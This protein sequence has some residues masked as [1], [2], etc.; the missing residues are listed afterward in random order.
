LQRWEYFFWIAI[1]SAAVVFHPSHLAIV[2]VLLVAAIIGWVLSTSISPSGVM[3]LAVAATIG[4]AS[5][6][7]FAFAVEKVLHVWVSRPPDLMARI[8]ADGPGAMYL[9][10]RCPQAGFLAC[11]FVDRLSQNSDQILWGDDDVYAPAP[12]SA[13]ALLG[14][15]QYQFEAAVLAYDP[16]AVITAALRDTF[17]QLKMAG[18]ASFDGVEKEAFPKLP[19]VYAEQLMTTR[20]WNKDFPIAIFSTLTVLVALLSSIFVG[21]TLIRNWRDISTAQKVFCFVVLFAQVANAAICG[22]FS[23]P[24][25]RYQARLTWLIPITALL[26]YYAM[27]ERRCSTEEYSAGQALSLPIASLTGRKRIWSR[28]ITGLSCRPV[29]GLLGVLGW[30]TKS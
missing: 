27:R 15:E 18:L 20:L 5:E 7:G 12:I 2:L 13:R 29:L 4:F 28:P 10:H 26:L 3:A 22:F 16:A 6:F 1:L 24:H 30:R 11:K 9:R 25:E 19:Q 8:I 23:G 21:A 14:D 17:Q